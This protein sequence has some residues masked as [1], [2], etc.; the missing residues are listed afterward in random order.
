[1]SLSL[2]KGVSLPAPLA[3][4]FAIACVNDTL[5]E[6]GYDCVITSAIDGKHSRGSLHYV[7]LA[8]DFRTNNMPSGELPRIRDKI[9]TRLGENFDFLLEKDHFHLELQPK[10]PIGA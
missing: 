3:M 10:T 8:L 9:A 6:E 7:G 1:M 5:R 4:A 2:K